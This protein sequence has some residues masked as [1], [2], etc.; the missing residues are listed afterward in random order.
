MPLHDRQG[1]QQRRVGGSARQEDG[2]AG[3]LGPGA[4]Q[5]EEDGRGLS[6]RAGDRGGHHRSRL[7]QRLPAPGDQ[8]R[9]PHRGPRREAH[10]QRAHGRGARVRPRQAGQERPQ[11]RGL[12]PGRGHVRHLDHRDRGRRRRAA[13][14]GALDQR[15]HLPGRRGLRPA[16]DRLPVRRVQEGVR[17]RPAQG[18]ARP[19][20]PEGRRREGQDRALVLAADRR[21]ICRTSRPTSRGPSTWRSRSRAPSSRAS[22]RS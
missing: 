8:G 17:H 3:S 18:H 5:D 21:S 1:R 16:P 19:A 13:V 20:A 9:R 2:P 22:S 11:D 6:R 15:R 7:L 10:H 12:R 14:R 4:D